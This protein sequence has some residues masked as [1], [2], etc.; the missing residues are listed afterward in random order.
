MRV[1]V[2]TSVWSLA[3]RRPPTI[4]N[5]EA[6]VLESLI[7]SGEEVFLL[8]IILQELLQGIRKKEIFDSLSNHLKYFPI[9]EPTREDYVA[10]AQLKNTLMKKCI[11]ISTIDALIA[12]VAIS[13]DCLLF[14]TDRDFRYIEKHT[15][16]RLLRY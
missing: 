9:I 16:L 2:D 6:R 10:A 4:K 11:Q 8:G 14:T 13:Y 5:K 12:S 7:N 1:I 3:L 15:A